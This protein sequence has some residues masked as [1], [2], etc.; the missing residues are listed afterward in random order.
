MYILYTVTKEFQENKWCFQEL[1][2]IPLL[3]AE[4]LDKSFMDLEISSKFFVCF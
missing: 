3:N 2:P 1:K 4:V